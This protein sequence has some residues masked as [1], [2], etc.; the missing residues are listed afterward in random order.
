MQRLSSSRVINDIE[1]II[2]RPNPALGQRKWLAMGAE[3]SI[4][5]HTFLGEVYG[6]HAE[7]LQIRL[8]A[9]GR[10]SWKVIIVSELW[11][12]ND[13]ENIHSTKWLKLLLG[14]PAEVLKWISANRSAM[15]PAAGEDFRS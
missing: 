2:D 7:V 5:R 6:F 10:A 1:F 13:G 8:P 14:N 3:C 11:Q 15:L 4:E 12:A 9:T